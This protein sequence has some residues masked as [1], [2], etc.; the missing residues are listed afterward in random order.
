MP[1]IRKTFS[2]RDGVQ[3]DDDDFIVRGNLVGIGTTVPTEKLD[4]RGN[5]VATGVVTSTN[6]YISGVSTFSEIRAGSGITISATSGIISA[7]TFFGD[8]QNLTNLPTS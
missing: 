7:T 8:G 5:L 4:I 6:L 1:N 2:F 3:V